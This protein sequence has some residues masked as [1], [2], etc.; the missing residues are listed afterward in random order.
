MDFF[1]NLG[2]SV[3]SNPDNG[4]WGY[5]CPDV[6]IHKEVGPRTFVEAQI[7]VNWEGH[8]KPTN[9]D[10][11]QS[12]ERKLGQMCYPD[13]ARGEKGY[14]M[15]ISN[16][17]KYAVACPFTATP[18]GFGVRANPR[19]GKEANA[20]PREAYCKFELDN[21]YFLNLT[22]GDVEPFNPKSL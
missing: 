22:S 3:E 9:W 11:F 10:A 21:C 17:L 14:W 18:L 8:G 20:N 6:V 1:S 2:Y 5:K 12:W 16:N 15:T 19:F 7:N 13:P 4:N